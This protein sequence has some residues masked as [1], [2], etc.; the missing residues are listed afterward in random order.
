LGRPH[1]E[2]VVEG[3]PEVPSLRLAPPHARG[4]R[5]PDD[6][7]TAPPSLASWHTS[8]SPPSPCQSRPRVSRRS[9]SSPGS[10]PSSPWQ[11]APVHG[12]LP[13]P[14]AARSSARLHGEICP[15]PVDQER[16]RRAPSYRDG[17]RTPL[18]ALSQGSCLGWGDRVSVQPRQPR[19]R[20]GQLRGQCVS[21]WVTPD[22]TSGQHC[23]ELPVWKPFHEKAPCRPA[24][25]VI[26]SGV[27]VGTIAVRRSS[28]AVRLASMRT[29]C[30]S[31]RWRRPWCS[32]GSVQSGA[33]IYPADCAPFTE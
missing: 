14:P 17:L 31:S 5:A 32:R 8:V 33:A 2:G 20:Y 24:F 21:D 30:G 19:P 15:V 4:C 23:P 1:D 9:S 28:C 25:S 10:E 3:R 7:A 27:L 22:P 16:L 29:R 6:G 18:E 13:K 12:A 11:S 26:S